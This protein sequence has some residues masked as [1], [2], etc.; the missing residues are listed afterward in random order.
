VPDVTVVWLW[1]P[2]HVVA[3]GFFEVSRKYANGSKI[4]EKE[5]EEGMLGCGVEGL[6]KERID[7]V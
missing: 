7:C 3:P 2:G 4:P 5:S 6:G 1:D